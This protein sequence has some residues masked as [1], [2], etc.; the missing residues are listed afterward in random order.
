MKEQLLALIEKADEQELK[1]LL[2]YTR[3]LLTKPEPKPK[4]SDRS[5]QFQ[6]YSAL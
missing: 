3:I 2:A 4:R 6:H 5:E 1:I